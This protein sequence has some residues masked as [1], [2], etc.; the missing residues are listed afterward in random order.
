M[1]SQRKS[2]GKVY[3][4]GNRRSGVALCPQPPTEDDLAARAAIAARAIQWNLSAAA[5]SPVK[6]FVDIVGAAIGLAI[7]GVAILP[8]AIAIKLDHPGPLFFGQTR[9]GYRGRPFRIWKFRSMVP[10]ADA[11]KHTVKNEAKGLIFKNESDP[12][13]TRVGR[14]LRRTSLDE[15]PQFFNVLR[16]EMSLVGTRPPVLGEVAAYEP[17]HW[18]RLAV[19][20]GMTGK[21][22]TS[23][24][25][26]IKDFEQIVAMD[27]AYQ[28]E[29]SL[30]ND[31]KIILKTIA[32]VFGSRDA[33]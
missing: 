28:S 26:R 8:I 13:I 1:Q 5:T 19:K 17:H 18:Q 31:F 30:W 20:P 6:R 14:F 10:D 22:Q 4:A 29:W 7:V 11:R 16:G 24:R 27:L 32:V 25:S 33:C 21:W 2:E 12:R 15:L 9:Y 23:G 3:P